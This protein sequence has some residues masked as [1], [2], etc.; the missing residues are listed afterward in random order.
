ML[1][2]RKEFLNVYDSVCNYLDSETEHIIQGLFQT[3]DISIGIAM[4][5]VQKQIGS[6][7][8]GVFA[9]VVL[10]TIAHGLN[11]AKAVFYQEKM[12]SH[13]ATCIKDRLFTQFPKLICVGTNLEQ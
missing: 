12:R 7:D 1:A 3:A 8:C 9:A 11:P 4:N 6:A 13:L 10:T 5:N 2:V